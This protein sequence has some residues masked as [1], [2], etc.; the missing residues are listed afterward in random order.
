MEKKLLRPHS[1]HGF[2]GLLSGVFATPVF[3]PFCEEGLAIRLF[4]IVAFA[5]LYHDFNDL[6][7]VFFLKKQSFKLKTR[8][9]SEFAGKNIIIF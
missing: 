7:T 4:P 6:S 2:D 9:L 8:V 1:E 3:A 5:I